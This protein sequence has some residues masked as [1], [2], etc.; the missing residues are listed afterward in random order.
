MQ[1]SLPLGDS[2]SQQVMNAFL[3]FCQRLDNDTN[4]I[5]SDFGGDPFHLKMVIIQQKFV[6]NDC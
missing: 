5:H 1:D 4:N 6:L 2:V 3:P